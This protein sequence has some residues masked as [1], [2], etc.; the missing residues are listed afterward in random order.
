MTD[1]TH[2]VRRPAMPQELQQVRDAAQDLAQ[3]ASRA[4]GR[5]RTV[6]ETVADVA[7]IGTA[8]ISG[9]LA[10][11]T[12]WKALFPR[13][14]DAHHPSAQPAASGGS[15]PLRK[16]HP[17]ASASDDGNALS[18]QHHAGRAKHALTA[19]H[20]PNGRY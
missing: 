8:V 6:F 3:Q 2:R 13:H 15:P 19:R 5:A 20:P 10:G 16:N 18:H 7:L 12:L 4:P 9:A 17:P 1:W 11:V 14:A